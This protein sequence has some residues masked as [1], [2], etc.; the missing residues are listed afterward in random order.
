MVSL[1]IRIK[2][3]VW[4]WIAFGCFC[5]I[6]SVD[7]FSVIRRPS[8]RLRGLVP[9]PVLAAA[10]AT[11]TTTTI[12]FQSEHGRGDHHLS[13][14]LEEGDV[15]VYQTGTWLV[16]GVEVGDGTD[17]QFHLC[18]LDALQIVW[19]HNCEH[20][21]LR[22]LQVVLVEEQQPP[23]TTTA[24]TTNPTKLTTG[25]TL[26]DVEFGPEQLV[27]RLPVIWNEDDDEGIS[28]VPLEDTI[29]D[30]YSRS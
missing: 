29:H 21:V 10:A 18:R 23:S 9:V 15:V 27:A 26:I 30:L 5:R 7:A 13:A 2:K 11:T 16:D 20:G 25:T 14:L 17:P 24:A 8:R 22:G 1:L 3:F 28:A 12:E 4:L 6:A 19:T